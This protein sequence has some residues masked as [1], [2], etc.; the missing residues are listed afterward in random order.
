MANFATLQERLLRDIGRHFHVINPQPRPIL[1]ILGFDDD[2]TEAIA[3]IT[4]I[5]NGIQSSWNCAVMIPLRLHLMIGISGRLCRGCSNASMGGG[6]R[7]L[8][9]LGGASIGGAEGQIIPFY[10]YI[11]IVFTTWTV[12]A[13]GSGVAG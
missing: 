7:E 4:R 9:V 8:W 6:E 1:F 5:L 11:E 3:H 2:R 12:E 13:G 10:F